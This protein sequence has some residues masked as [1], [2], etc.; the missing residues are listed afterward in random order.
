MPTNSQSNLLL[1][2]TAS[3]VPVETVAIVYGLHGNE[4][5]GITL[6]R[7]WEED[8]KL[9]QRP[10]FKTTIVQGNPLADQR[11]VRFLDVDMNRCFSYDSLYGNPFGGRPMRELTIARTV[12]SKLGGKRPYD[13]PTDFVL[14]LHNTTSNMGMT[15]IV[16]RLSPFIKRLA[17]HLVKRHPNTH[18]L[19]T[20]EDRTSSVYCDSL[21]RDGMTLEV[22]PVKHGSPDPETAEKEA[23]L[24]Y[25]LLNFIELW[26]NGEISMEPKEISVYEMLA[27][28]HYPPGGYLYPG[29]LGKDYQEVKKGEPLLVLE[30]GDVQVWGLDEPVWPTFIGEEAYTSTEDDAVM[31][32]TNKGTYFW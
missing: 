27:S 28:V 10:S 30:N 23:G 19:M 24:V 17:A 18:I 12:A 8:T 26:N 13:K 4:N 21:G 31:M 2:Y 25:D 9:V 32:L 3:K 29:L 7:K 6:G 15:I 16:S 5:T 14:D 22:G 20:P 1:N 11:N